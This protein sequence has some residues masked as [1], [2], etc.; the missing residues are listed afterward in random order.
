MEVSHGYFSMQIGGVEKNFLRTMPRF[1]QSNEISHQLVLTHPVGPL[2]DRLPGDLKLKS[3]D[4]EKLF[5]SLYRLYQNTDVVHLYTINENPVHRL[6]AYLANTPIIDN[7]RN[8]ITVPHSNRV[9]RVT[10]ASQA[11]A[12]VQDCPGKTKV[13]PNGV[14]I[15]KFQEPSYEKF[16][17]GE[18]LQL[19]EIGRAD[20]KRTFRAEDFMPALNQ[21]FPDIKCHVLGREGEDRDGIIYHGYVEEPDKFYK[22]SHFLTHFVEIEPF[23]MTPLEAYRGGAIPVVSGEGGIR[24]IIQDSK[25]G[26]FLESPG[27]EEIIEQLKRIAEKFYEQ[28]SFWIPMAQNGFELVSNQYSVNNH[29]DSYNSLYKRLSKINYNDKFP[30]VKWSVEF[31]KFFYQVTLGD[32]EFSPEKLDRDRFSSPLERDLFRIIKTDNLLDKQPESVVEVLDN[33]ESVPYR[34][35]YEVWINR[36]RAYQLIDKLERAAEAAKEALNQEND[37]PEPYLL[38]AE[39]YIKKG[40]VESAMKILK[41]YKKRE[42]TYEP[43]NEMLR[44]FATL[45]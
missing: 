43:V 40:D 39:T 31:D 45:R 24:E 21:Y 15:D 13:I 35:H 18:S 19:I 30:E 42:P 38:L 6:P 22:K 27:K 41:K 1:L 8:M 17:S 2:R 36:A 3:P 44:K 29:V 33:I 11:I 37:L 20:K 12:S 32:Y 16:K 28:P 25:T 10:C 14:E 9:T 7:P 4:H 34:D 26:Y 23:G 5:S